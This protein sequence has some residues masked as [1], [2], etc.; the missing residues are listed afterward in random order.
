M[1]TRSAVLG[2]VTGVAGSTKVSIFV[3]PS[4][5]TWIVKEVDVVNWTGV[6]VF[7]E[8]AARDSTHVLRGVCI[9]QSVVNGTR[10]QYNGFLVCGPGD[11]LYVST[12]NAGALLWVSGAKLLGF[13]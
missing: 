3:V 5:Q 13:V 4:G 9:Y 6:D 2:R 7:V 1:S 8:V 10:A 12:D 11:E